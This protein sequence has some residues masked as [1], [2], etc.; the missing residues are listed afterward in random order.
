MTVSSSYSFLGSAAGQAGRQELIRFL[1][2]FQ[3]LRTANDGSLICRCTLVSFVYADQ[4]VQ[5]SMLLPCYL[6]LNLN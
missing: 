1:S 6:F 3:Q 4:N 5:T 2:C